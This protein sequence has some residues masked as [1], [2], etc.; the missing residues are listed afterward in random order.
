MASKS[1]TWPIKS[2]ASCSVVL[3]LCASHSAKFSPMAY[4]L[5]EKSATYLD[6]W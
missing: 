2:P 3:S 5:E 6:T 4:P 1:S